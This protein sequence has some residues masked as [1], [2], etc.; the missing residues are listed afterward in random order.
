MN[1][2]L[3]KHF[4]GYILT[5][6]MVKIQEYP[7][8]INCDAF[9]VGGCVIFTGW[10]K[11]FYESDFEKDDETEEPILP[12]DHTM[13]ALVFA[14]D[15]LLKGPQSFLA[16]PCEKVLWTYKGRPRVDENLRWDGMTID[17]IST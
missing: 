9:L 11:L 15:G 10:S 3:V 4:R 2:Y 14:S 6:C 12:E 17:D 1:P 8:Y 5:D 13:D 16:I 7:A